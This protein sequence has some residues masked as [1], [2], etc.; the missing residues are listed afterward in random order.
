MLANIFKQSIYHIN[1]HKC[2]VKTS[3]TLDTYS[4]SSAEGDNRYIKHELSHFKSTQVLL[5]FHTKS[6]HQLNRYKSTADRRQ[7]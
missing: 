2:V 1:K 6:I 7:H 5:C 4:Q 3:T